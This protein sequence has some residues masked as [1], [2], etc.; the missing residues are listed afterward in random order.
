MRYIAAGALTAITY[1]VLKRTGLYIP[2]V[3]AIAVLSL[4]TYRK[5]SRL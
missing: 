5:W 2:F 3:M 4:V 1:D